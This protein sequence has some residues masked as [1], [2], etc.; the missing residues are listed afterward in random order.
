MKKNIYQRLNLYNKVNVGLNKEVD[1][2]ATNLP[3]FDV[4]QERI[5]TIT[6]RLAGKPSLISYEVY[7]TTE[8]GWLIMQIND[9]LDPFEELYIGREI[10][11][12]PLREYFDFYS[13]NKRD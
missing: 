2:L 7:G 13:D 4:R 9:I 12:P 8:L 5:F 11:I 3:D 6:A 10:K 1:L